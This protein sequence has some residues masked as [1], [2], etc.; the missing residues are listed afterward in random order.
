MVLVATIICQ[1]PLWLGNSSLGGSSSGNYIAG[2]EES[3]FPRPSTSGRIIRDPGTISWLS[4]YVSSM[5]PCDFLWPFIQQTFC[6]CLKTALQFFDLCHLNLSPA[7]LRAGGGCDL[8][9]RT[10]YPCADYQVLR[11]L[12]E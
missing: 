3:C 1:N 2:R 7:S 11:L 6:A 8:D 5:P 12:G 10:R 4:R 9:V